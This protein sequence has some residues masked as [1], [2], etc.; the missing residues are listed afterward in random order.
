MNPNPF[1]TSNH[2]TVP[3][4]M[5]AD[6]KHRATG[7][8]FKRVRGAP[9]RALKAMERSMMLVVLLRKRIYLLFC[10]GVGE[11]NNQSVLST[12]QNVG[13]RKTADSRRCHLPGPTM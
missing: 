9:R 10:A 2:L 5:T 12:T 13:K 8:L 7:I 6:D 11:G 1:L 4:L 3:E